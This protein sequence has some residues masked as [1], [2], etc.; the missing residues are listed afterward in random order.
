MEWIVAAVL[1]GLIPAWIASKKG[2]SFG[3]W[4]V[5]GTLLFIIAL[6]WAIFMRDRRAKCGYC[7]SALN[8]I[9]QG[10]RRVVASVCAACGRA[11]GELPTE[12]AGAPRTAA[13]TSRRTAVLV[14]VLVAGTIVV[15]GIPAIYYFTVMVPAASSEELPLAIPAPTAPINMVEPVMVPPSTPPVVA[16][17][18][19]T[20][21][22]SAPRR[23]KAAKGDKGEGWVDPFGG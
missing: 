20:N 18:P 8:V 12:G 10:G 21:E 3:A 9:E 5:V 15:I 2:E 19:A 14:A 23:R 11:Q 7:G 13:P 22:P 6:P 16:P 1:L 17:V 4:W